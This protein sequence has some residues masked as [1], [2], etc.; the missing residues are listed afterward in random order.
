MRRAL[1]W[2]SVLS[3]CGL[4]AA[5]NGSGCMTYQQDLDRA[6]RHYEDNQFEQAL[7]LFR[8]LEPDL[9]S[10]DS[11]QQAK[12]AYYRGMTD[13][14][15]AGLAAQGTTVTD[16]RKGFRDNARHWLAVAMAISQ[17]TPGGLTDDQKQ[18]A[19]EAL[20]ELNKDFYTGAEASNELPGASKSAG[21][22]GA[23]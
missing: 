2:I 14:R 9:D 21:D 10:F 19:T 6:Q 3:L 5:F 8:V 13:F 17:Q 20:G 23:P 1:A 22:A 7:A 4:A 11:P 16:P 12:Y 15:L 18:R